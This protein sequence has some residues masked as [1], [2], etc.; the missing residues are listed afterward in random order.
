VAVNVGRRAR[1]LGAAVACCAVGS[2]AVLG[3]QSVNSSATVSDPCT[4]PK[5]TLKAVRGSAVGLDS[6]GQCSGTRMRM[7]ETLQIQRLI[8]LLSDKAEQVWGTV[9]GETI[10]DSSDTGPLALGGG[11]GVW[12]D[13]SMGSI[14][15]TQYG[16]RLT[17]GR[18]RGV[19]S[20]DVRSAKGQHSDTT[21]TKTVT[22]G[23]DFCK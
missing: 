5:L 21:V 18:Y 3:V 10:I 23:A 2:G 13:P 11:F 20:F 1:L 22:I 17:P 15:P 7:T 4:K 6:S 8:P 19:F 16:P 9:A 14:F 12:C